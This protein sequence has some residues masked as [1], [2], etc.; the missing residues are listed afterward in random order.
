MSV[1]QP[2]ITNNSVP[3]VQEPAAGR[4]TITV[5]QLIAWM[6][7]AIPALVAAKDKS[8]AELVAEMMSS[9]LSLLTDG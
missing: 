1:P 3:Q 5:K 9:L 4:D 2:K 8:P 6:T 7:K